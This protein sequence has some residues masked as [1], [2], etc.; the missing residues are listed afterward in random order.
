MSLASRILPG[1]ALLLAAG[2]TPLA[3]A[4]AP[5]LVV[6]KFHAD[7]CSAC[8]AM[9]D[10]ATDLANKHDGQPILFVT[11]DLTNETTRRQ[12]EMRAAA[13]GLSALYDANRDKTGFLVLVN[14]Q[15]K[16]EVTKLTR[17]QTLKDMSGAIVAA[18]PKP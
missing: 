9:G 6:A 8:R 17:E 18:L 13:M 7:W 4:Q 3:A 5:A 11:F 15:S 14:A 2:L 10:V 1:A 16:T 12:S